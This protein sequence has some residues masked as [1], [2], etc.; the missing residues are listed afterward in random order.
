MKGSHFSSSLDVSLASTDGDE[1]GTSHSRFIL[2]PFR[3]PLHSRELVSPSQQLQQGSQNP[4]LVLSLPRDAGCGPLWPAYLGTYP[5]GAGARCSAPSNWT[6]WGRGGLQGETEDCRESKSLVPSVAETSFFLSA[7]SDP[8]MLQ[9]RV[10]VLS[11]LP[12][13]VPFVTQQWCSHLP[14]LKPHFSFHHECF[15]QLT[16]HQP[17]NL[18]ANSFPSVPPPHPLLR[19]LCCFL[20]AGLTASLSLQ[21]PVL[22][23][24]AWHVPPCAPAFPGPPRLQNSLFCCHSLAQTPGLCS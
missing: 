1:H 21:V 7:P 4:S 16:S 17:R 24:F 20:H 13:L 5:W 2:Y 10:W 6:E 19:P 8:L 15:L 23:C 18:G 3:S 22:C 11:L 9:R 12:H 14:S